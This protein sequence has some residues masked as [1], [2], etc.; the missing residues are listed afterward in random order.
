MP[1]ETDTI[2][3]PVQEALPVLLLTIPQVAS[4]LHVSR[5]KV[6]ELIRT[7][8]LPTFDC[9]GRKRVPLHALQ[10]WID[11]HTSSGTEEPERQQNQA[12]RLH[13]SLYTPPFACP[14]SSRKR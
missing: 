3:E 5:A 10:A 9:G 11:A 6:Y 2:Q 7:H 12:E 1:E 4:A 14:P 8:G 13:A